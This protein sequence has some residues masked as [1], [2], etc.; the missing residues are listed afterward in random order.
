M[1][2]LIDAYI[3]SAI[4]QK[5]L[6][7]GEDSIEESIK[8]K[9]NQEGIEDRVLLKGYM[10]NPYPYIKDAKALVLASNAEGL[11]T[12]LIEALILGTPVV[13]TDCPT[14]PKEILTGELAEFLSPVGDRDA[15]AHNIRK[16]IENPP[17]ILEEHIAKFHKDI[18]VRKYLN[19]LN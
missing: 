1:L 11:P 17:K 12:V 18:S 8:D 16:V 5:L 4:K 10:D 7:I 13:S 19:L 15:L 9:I 14:G 3:R 6:L 2:I